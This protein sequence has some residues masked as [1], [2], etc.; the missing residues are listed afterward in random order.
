MTEVL[1]L[2]SMFE[3]LFTRA[4]HVQ[5]PLRA[6]LAACGYDVARPKPK[7]PV[8]LWE[9]CVDVAIA[10]LTPAAPR[11]EAWVVMGRRFIEGYFQTLVGKLIATSLPFLTARSFVNRVPRFMSTGLEGTEASV[12]WADERHVTL[13]IRGPRAI[14]ASFMTGILAVCFERMKVQPVTMAAQ[15]LGERSAVLAITLP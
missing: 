8:D 9:Q 11:E 14:S 2:H 3:G 10:E 5:E 7:Y 6:R 13:T 1:A 4:L 12:S 15:V